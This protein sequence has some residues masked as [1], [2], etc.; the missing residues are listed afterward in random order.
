VDIQ[1]GHVRGKRVAVVGGSIAGCAAAR[2]LHR[3]G[4]GEVVV[5]ERAS[6]RLQ[7]RGV[8]LAIQNER[9]AELEAAGY[10]DARM[11][12]VA[13][14]RRPW[15]VRDGALRQGR[16]IASLSFPYRSYNWG[17]LW[18]ELRHRLP[19]TVDYRNGAVV[20]TVTDGADHP[21]GTDRATVT[22]ADGTEE[23]FDLVVGADGYRSTVRA[24]ML[25]PGSAAPVWGGYLAWRGTVP[26]EQLPD[27]AEAFPEDTA[28]TVVFPGG[29]MIAYRIPGTPDGDGGTQVNWVFYA[30]PPAHL[31]ALLA[32]PEATP[33]AELTQK[34]TDYQLGV[35]ER[36]FPGYWRD[37]VHGT[38]KE[39][40]LLQPIHDV[41]APRF[42]HGR[43]VLLGD[44]AAIARPHT[45][46]G[47][48]K[49]LQDATVLGRALAEADSL[50]EG[51]AAYDAER[52]PVGRAILELGRG[53]G[54]A[55]VQQTP[56]WA[57]MD[58]ASFDAWWQANNGADVGGRPL[59]P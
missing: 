50:P 42:A 18:Q 10:L 40:R 1:G 33:S 38:P 14:A 41:A 3:A 25:P 27:P 58:Q 6:G 15:V 4:A 52:A 26:A 23:R 9:Y 53:L 24:A 57:S 56:D 21:D 51:L 2:A 5:L 55:H 17:S 29:H 31:A 20:H 11:P 39:T 43:L 12:W 22:L 28:T 35:V 13:L 36:H 44:A 34:L 45:G 59:K 8:G 46:S 47:A 19:D 7:D 16:E 32:D 49:A 48:L 54:R 37:V 30:T